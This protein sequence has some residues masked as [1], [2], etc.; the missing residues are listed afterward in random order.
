MRSIKYKLRRQD[1][2]KINRIRNLR[3]DM[4]LVAGGTDGGTTDL[5]M[6][7][8]ELINAANPK[9]RLGTSY[10]LSPSSS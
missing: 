9:P 3:P 10:S 8:A 6:Q 4:L 5:V 1:Y 7:I 2:Q